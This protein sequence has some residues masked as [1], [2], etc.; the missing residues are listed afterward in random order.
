MQSYVFTSLQNISC[1]NVG[2]LHRAIKSNVSDYNLVYLLNGLGHKYEKNSK[3]VRKFDK[4]SLETLALSYEPLV[5]LGS[6]G[7]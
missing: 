3:I 6:N 1:Q 5:S 7:V 2:R 4:F